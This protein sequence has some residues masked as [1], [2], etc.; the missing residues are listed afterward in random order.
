MLIH[1]AKEKGE[2]MNIITDDPRLFL[3]GLNRT[4]TKFYCQE[5]NME[6]IPRR[7]RFKVSNPVILEI[8]KKEGITGRLENRINLHEEDTLYLVLYKESCWKIFMFQVVDRKG[9]NEK[10]I[11]GIW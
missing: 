4:K 10:K 7:V 5:V 8:V 2:K 1:T 3:N 11:L 6:D 9:N